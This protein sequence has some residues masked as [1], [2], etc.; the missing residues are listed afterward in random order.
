[1]LRNLVIRTASVRALARRL[2][3]IS[4]MS[5]RSD[6]CT[7]VIGRRSAFTCLSAMRI[8]GS[9]PTSVISNRP[10]NSCNA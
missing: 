10:G 2:R 6:A 1:M 4:A 8:T 5:I 3:A 7:T 9:S